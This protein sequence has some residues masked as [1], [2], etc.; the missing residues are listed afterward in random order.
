MD[1]D[2]FLGIE[3]KGQ[4]AAAIANVIIG[5]N[6]FKTGMI[7]FNRFSSHP[8]VTDGGG[9]EHLLIPELISELTDRTYNATLYSSYLFRFDETDYL[10]RLRDLYGN[11]AETLMRIV[12]EARESKQIQPGYFHNYQP[13]AI[14]LLTKQ[15]ESLAMVDM[16][17]HFDQRQEGY[18][19]HGRE[20]TKVDP[21]QD[22]IFTIIKVRRN[23]LSR[24]NL[25]G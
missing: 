3:A 20:R 7:V 2:R 22:H 11:K 8:L 4:L 19:Y 25:I 6:D 14:F 13:P 23:P 9:I 1:V 10:A 18:L 16:G 15:G 5:M 12:K 21:H 24:N 17:I